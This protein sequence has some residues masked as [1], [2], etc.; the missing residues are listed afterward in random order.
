LRLELG[1]LHSSERRSSLAD[2][3]RWRL[4][5]KLPEALP[6]DAV[7]IDELR[8]RREAQVR[9]AAACQEAVE[10]E[11]E[12][13]RERAGESHR[14]QLLDKQLQAW[15]QTA[16]LRAYAADL[17]QRIAEAG[18]DGEDGWGQPTLLGAG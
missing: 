2:R 6:E 13:A 16:E 10:Q 9:A 12:H 5:D 15:R 11:R 4:E 3:R 17:S 8:M 18:D 1:T 7:R 14:R